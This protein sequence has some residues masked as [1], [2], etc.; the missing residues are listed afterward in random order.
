M[1]SNQKWFV[2]QNLHFLLPFGPKYSKLSN[3]LKNRYSY[4]QPNVVSTVYS[5]RFQRF[6][7]W[8]LAHRALL[9]RSQCCLWVLDWPD[10]S[11]AVCA[12][13]GATHCM[14]GTGLVWLC[15]LDLGL[16]W[17]KLTDWSHVPEPAWALGQLSAVDCMHCTGLESAH[18]ACG[19][20]A[21][22]PW[23]RGRKNEVHRRETS[24]SGLPSKSLAEQA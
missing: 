13:P 24:W 11:H 16:A 5:N 7:S 20:G 23:F 3:F 4:S 17:I 2:L 12:G 10:A 19:M 9:C 18:V 14:Q 15:L 21:G 8:D 6:D 1:V 22:F